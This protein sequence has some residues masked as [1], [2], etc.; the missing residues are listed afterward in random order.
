MARTEQVSSVFEFEFEF[1]TIKVDVA[2]SHHFYAG[3]R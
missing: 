2:N 1:S 3:R